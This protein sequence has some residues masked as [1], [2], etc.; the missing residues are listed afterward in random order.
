M[1]YEKGHGRLE[2][3]SIYRVAVTPEEIGLC[4][5]WQV[6]GVLREREE[7]NPEAGK[8]SYVGYYVTSLSYE[9]YSDEQLQEIIRQHWGIENGVHYRRDVCFEEDKCRVNNRV[10]AH[11]LASLR[12]LAISLYQ[13]QLQNKQTNVDSCRSWCRRMSFSSAMKLLK[14]RG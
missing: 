12:N 8:T 5:C 1:I 14:R 7:L 13:Y 11:A 6:V 10:A 9:E 2:G 3:R 4:G